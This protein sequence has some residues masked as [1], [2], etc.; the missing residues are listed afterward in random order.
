MSGWVSPLHL[1]PSPILLGA[2]RGGDGARRWAGRKGAR[3]P[4]EWVVLCGG[5]D[6]TAFSE[7]LGANC[8]L[9]AV[10]LVSLLLLQCHLR[11]SLCDQ[12]IGPTEARRYQYRAN[13]AVF[14]VA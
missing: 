5:V 10:I 14:C 13:L 2:L 12:L 1:A 11:V 8:E 9:H 7:G 6:L 4:T 3:L